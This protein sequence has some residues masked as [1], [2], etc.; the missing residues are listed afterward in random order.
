[1]FLAACL[2]FG[3]GG[4]R[5]RARTETSSSEEDEASR[6][7]SDGASE[8]EAFSSSSSVPS[9][10]PPR[11]SRRCARTSLF[12][13]ASSSRSARSAASSNAA[14]AA[15]SSSAAAEDDGVRRSPSRSRSRSVRPRTSS[16][17]SPVRLRA[18]PEAKSGGFG[19]R[20]PGGSGPP[21]PSASASAS[22]PVVVKNTGASTSDPSLESS[23]SAMVGTSNRVAPKSASLSR[24]MESETTENPEGRSCGSAPIATRDTPRLARVARW[25]AQK[26]RRYSRAS[27]NDF[28]SRNVHI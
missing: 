3:L 27:S 2:P 21:N 24:R 14:S 20:R 1:M 7:S 13:R 18:A 26:G 23:P 12:E 4:G 19:E 10:R 16:L 5:R 11:A 6:S 28:L 25:C 22:D 8:R 9:S 15:A 17:R